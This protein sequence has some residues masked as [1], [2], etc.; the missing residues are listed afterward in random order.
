MALHELWGEG[1]VCF[2]QG[3]TVHVSRGLLQQWSRHQTTGYKWRWLFWRQLCCTAWES[4]LSH[5]IWWKTFLNTYS[6]C[7]GL[8]IGLYAKRKK[9]FMDGFWCNDTGLFAPAHSSIYNEMHGNPRN[10]QMGIIQTARQ[11]GRKRSA[12]RTGGIR[13]LGHYNNS[14]IQWICQFNASIA[15]CHLQVCRLC[16]AWWLIHFMVV[17]CGLK[18]YIFHHHRSFYMV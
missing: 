11:H 18:L 8:C 16:L 1:W 10:C 13:L 6:H 4:K 17:L 2:M 14:N 12:V 5:P 7:P 3:D 9:S 15:S